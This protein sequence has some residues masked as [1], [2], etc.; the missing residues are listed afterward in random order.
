MKKFINGYRRALEFGTKHVRIKVPYID[1]ELYGVLSLDN[2]DQRGYGPGTISYRIVIPEAYVNAARN[3]KISVVCEY[4][5]IKDDT[6]FDNSNIKKYSWILWLSDM[7]EGRIPK[8][9]LDNTDGHFF[10]GATQIPIDLSFQTKILS[11]ANDRKIPTCRILEDGSGYLIQG[12]SS[13]KIF[14]K[15]ELLD[16]KES[17]FIFQ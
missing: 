16:L 17:T 15:D 7:I 13:V 12:A 6:L 8:A 5:N 10:G 3:A 9:F 11:Q 4:Y 2:A 1:N 14:I